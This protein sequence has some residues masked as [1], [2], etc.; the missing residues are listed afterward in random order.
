MREQL[1]RL[2]D[3]AE[4]PL[5]QGGARIFVETGKCV[6]VEPHHARRTVE[7]SEQPRRGLAGT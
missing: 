3:E 7:P 6:A 1:E 5:P 4:E 2:E